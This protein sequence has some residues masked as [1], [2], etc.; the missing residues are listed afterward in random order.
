MLDRL[1]EA[2]RELRLQAQDNP[3]GG[4]L[5]ALVLQWQERWQA[6][7]AMYRQVLE[8]RLP[9]ADDDA[10]ALRDCVAAYDGLAF[11]AREQHTYAVAESVYRDALQ[12]LPDSAKPHFHY[13][14]GQHLHQAGRPSEA[15]D[16]FRTAATLRPALYAE[17]TQ[18]YV[19]QIRRFTPTCL[20]SWRRP[21]P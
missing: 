12:R 15:L 13:R 16:Q 20:N 1:A 18:R 6:S 17:R 5:L 8:G 10:Q 3:S 21:W 9:T 19:D 2:E 11:N 14:L 7:S 4:L